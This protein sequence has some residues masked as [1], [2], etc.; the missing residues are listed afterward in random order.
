MRVL[1]IARSQHFVTWNVLICETFFLVVS[2]HCGSLYYCVEMRSVMSGLWLYNNDNLYSAR[3][4]WNWNC[5]ILFFVLFNMSMANRFC[6]TLS[7]QWSVQDVHYNDKINKTTL[8]L[9]MPV[10]TSCKKFQLNCTRTAAVLR[11][12][13]ILLINITPLITETLE[14]SNDWASLLTFDTIIIHSG[15]YTLVIDC[16]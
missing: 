4:T 3:W 6:N 15:H 8:I 14:Q 10:I 7:I 13:G 9:I 11:G 5:L 12:S 2:F 1:F 16:H